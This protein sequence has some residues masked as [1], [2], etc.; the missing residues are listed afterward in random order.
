MIV[1]IFKLSLTSKVLQAKL[2]VIL[3]Q[4]L[5]NEQS[6]QLSLKLFHATLVKNNKIIMMLKKAVLAEFL[7]NQ[8]K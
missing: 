3:D 8:L 4:A 5:L 7:K 2:S 6:K 1:E